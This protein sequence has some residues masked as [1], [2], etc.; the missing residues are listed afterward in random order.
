MSPTL[1]LAPSHHPSSVVP[2]TAKV[3]GVAALD[4]AQLLAS[5]REGDETAATAL[6]LRVRPAI[7]R[8]LHRLL[9]PG[10][11]ELEDLAQHAVIELIT[12]I[13]RFRGDCSLDTWA[14][15]ITAHAVYNEIRGRRVKRKFFEY[16]ELDSD[17]EIPHAETRES[18]ANTVL[19]TRLLAKLRA[20]LAAMDPAKAM[21]YWLHDVCGYD[22]KEVA[23]ITD[24]SVAA[25]QTR[26][27]RGRREL[28]ERMAEDPELRLGLSNWEGR[29]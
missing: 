5:L 7:F 1:N 29:S 27:V 9:G 21:S 24:S 4:D 13:D 26:L 18:A 8:T 17:A 23:Q 15:R 14:S 28:H 10:D 6:C 25:A 19:A 22:L 16:R 12:T 20:H 2:A 3:P 11:G